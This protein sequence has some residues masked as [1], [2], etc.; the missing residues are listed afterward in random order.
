MHRMGQDA[1]LHLVRDEGHERAQELE[2]GVA[3]AL[4][5]CVR[6]RPLRGSPARLLR[7]RRAPPAPPR[8]PRC[9]LEL[10]RQLPRLNTLSQNQGQPE[11]I[12]HTAIPA[13]HCLV[14]GKWWL[15]FRAPSI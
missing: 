5:L 1:G 2:V 6:Q 12:E 10:R 11:P 3:H 9:R 7:K 8:H 15:L 4:R 14:M 13:A